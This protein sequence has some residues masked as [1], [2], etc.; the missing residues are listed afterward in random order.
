MITQQNLQKLKGRGKGICID[1]TY[2]A[3]KKRSKGGF[4][5]YTSIGNKTAVLGM[6]ELDLESRTTT[7][8]VRLIVMQGSTTAIIKAHIEKH[9]A[10]GSLIFTDSFKSYRFLSNSG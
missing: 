5:G 7:G 10:K 4:R 6:I 1:E 3:K 9:V 2:V 8:N